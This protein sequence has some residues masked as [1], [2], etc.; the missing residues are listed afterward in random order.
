MSD[1]SNDFLPTV[2]GFRT[3]VLPDNGVQLDLQVAMTLQDQQNR[4]FHKTSLAMH[5]SIA[6]GLATALARTAE[7]QTEDQPLQ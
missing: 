5:R 1:D 7:G 3:Y 4:R 6:T 2:V